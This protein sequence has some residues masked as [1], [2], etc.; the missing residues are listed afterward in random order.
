MRLAALTGALL[1][2]IV[3][4]SVL[5][6]SGGG[7]PR[8][9]ITP[10]ASP[11]ASPSPTPAL[12]PSVGVAGA[13]DLMTPAEAGTALRISSAVTAQPL[14]ALDINAVGPPE[15][16]F[17]EFHSGSTSL[18]V[19]RYERETG[20][21]A[22]ASWKIVKGVEAVPGLGDEAVWDPAKGTMYILKGIRLVTILPLDRPTPTLTLAAAKAI[23]AFVVG[24]M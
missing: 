17:C 11:T 12:S 5:L 8:A 22:F 10:S 16:W 3:G 2:A 1:V 19:L 18:F 6:F 20:A 15:S 7:L 13:C 14:I 24:R 4:G 9:P 21:N 23:G